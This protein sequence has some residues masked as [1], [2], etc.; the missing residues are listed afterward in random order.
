MPVLYHHA[1]LGASFETL[2]RA[3]DGLLLNWPV[4][5]VSLFDTADGKHPAN[6]YAVALP[7]AKAHGVN[8]PP[9]RVATTPAD[10]E[11]IAKE[12]RGVFRFV[13]TRMPMQKGKP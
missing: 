7:A 4:V 12:N 3:A 11:A 10:A 2:R 8:I 9:G 13:P 5:E 1:P 6:H